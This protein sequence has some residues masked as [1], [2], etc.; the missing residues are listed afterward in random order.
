[1]S[2]TQRS[3]RLSAA[4]ILAALLGARPSADSIAIEILD[5]TLQVTTVL[6]TGIAQPIGIVFLSAN[7]FLVLERASG[8]VK[9]VIDGVIQAAPVL[10]LA[11]NSNSERG[12]LSLALHPSFAT[13]RLVYVRWTQSSTGADSA[14]NVQVPLLGQPRGPL[15]V[16]RHDPHVRPRNRAAAGPADRQHRGHRTP[17][18]QQRQPRREPQRRRHPVRRRRQALHL[19]GRPGPARLDAEPREWSLRNGAVRGR[20]LRRSGAGQRASVRRH[21]APE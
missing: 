14:V 12:L 1:M 5:P 3:M 7:D 20:H 16:E 13:N 10:D 19:H 21:S 11:V 9:R 2:L 18:H 8:Q 15:R 6:N 17:W 4:L